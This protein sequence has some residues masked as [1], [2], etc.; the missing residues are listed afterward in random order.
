M[1]TACIALQLGILFA[2]CPQQRYQFS[3]RFLVADFALTSADVLTTSRII[4]RGGRE[5]WDAWLTGKRP[6]LGCTTLAQFGELAVWQGSAYLL[7]RHGHPKMAAFMQRV[8]V[9]AES[10]S[11]INNAEVLATWGKK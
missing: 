9:G 1:N 10:A 6:G 7:A 3:K 2:G 11:V 4:S 5:S 8:R